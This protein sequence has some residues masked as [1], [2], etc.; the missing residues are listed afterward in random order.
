[1]N[2]K[3]YLFWGNKL[4]K[5]I[6]IKM[7]LKLWFMVLAASMI[8]LQFSCKD[9]GVEPVLPSDTTWTFL[10]LKGETIN[11]MAI[12]P[13]DPDIIYVS[14]FRKLLKT[15]DGGNTWDSLYPTGFFSMAIDPRN[16]ETVYGGLGG[17]SKSTDGGHTWKS[18]SEGIIDPGFQSV[19][20][21]EIDPENSNI[22]YTGTTGLS[23]GAFYKSVD[24]GSSWTVKNTNSILS[25]AIDPTNSS[26]IYIGGDGVFKSTDA[27]ENWTIM[28]RPSVYIPAIV[29]DPKNS[30]KIIA[31]CGWKDGSL[32]KSENGGESWETFAEGIPDISNVM[33]LASRQ[34]NSDLYAVVIN[35]EGGGIYRRQN[36]DTQWQK[37]GIDSVEVLDYYNDVKIDPNERYLYFGSSGVFRL[38]IN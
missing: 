8:A 11:S 29:V 34:S 26:I 36:S 7:Q 24:A 25:M 22:L 13:T 37:I 14:G 12:D 9:N 2:I 28:G 31:G 20:V 32:F 3:S 16:P 15:T 33:R 38:K 19:R 6:S 10:G 30:T 23:G 18:S 17:I 5:K 4:M 27:G 35:T 21:L 1:M